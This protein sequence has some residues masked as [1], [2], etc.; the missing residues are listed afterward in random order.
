VNVASFLSSATRAN[1]AA[2]QS[3]AEQC[4]SRRFR[5]VHAASASSTTASIASTAFVVSA[6]FITTGSAVVAVMTVASH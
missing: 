5:D 3:E 2:Q 6:A 4:K 1:G